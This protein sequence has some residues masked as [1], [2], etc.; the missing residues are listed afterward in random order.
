MRPVFLRGR[1]DAPKHPPP[2]IQ[3]DPP[4][5]RRRVL[6]TPR[7]PSF[8]RL[9]SHT[10]PPRR[11]VSSLTTRRVSL[12]TPSLFRL[13]TNS[14][15]NS[16]YFVR[17]ISVAFLL[18]CQTERT[19][20]PPFRSL[21]ADKLRKLMLTSRRIRDTLDLRASFTRICPTN[22]IKVVSTLIY[23]NDKK[24]RVTL[25]LN[26]RQFS[27]VQR[28]AEQYGV[29]PSEFLRM[30]I[31]ASMFQS[32]KFDKAIESAVKEGGAIRREN[33][34]AHNDDIV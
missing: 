30:V 20:T 13:S 12:V 3:S 31:N 11:A 18:L 21:S 10:R 26:D 17:Q 33:E 6:N 5:V 1:T 15:K 29:S 2:D 19:F 22:F 34:N 24:T 23:T 14:R 9:F 32:E 25:R 16:R 8:I 4:F 28:S 7:P 27:F